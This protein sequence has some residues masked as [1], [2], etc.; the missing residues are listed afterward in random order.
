M[1]DCTRAQRAALLVG[2]QERDEP[3]VVERVASVPEF[4]GRTRQR[5]HDAARIRVDRR[6]RRVD[7]RE[8]VRL[9]PR[10]RRE[11]RPV[12]AL[13]D[14]DPQ[15]EVAW[16]EREAL[17]QRQDVAAYV[18]DGVRGTFLLVEDEQVVLAEHALRQVPEQHTRLGAGDPAP[19]R[20]N[21]APRHSFT[22]T[23]GERFEQPTHRPD[24]GRDPGGAVDDLRP[25]RT[26][27]TKPGVVG[28]ELLGDGGDR[29]E[30]GAQRLREVGGRQRIPPRHAA[31]DPLGE[32][33]VEG[34]EGRRRGIVGTQLRLERH[35]CFC[36]R[37]FGRSTFT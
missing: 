20:R 34:V 28:D 7:Q 32:P 3:A 5:L 31:G 10:H 27:C 2:C 21:R 13:V 35:D 6:Q 24:V 1:S 14:G 17:L 4:F 26:G 25:R 19:D 36:P 16:P 18:V 12:R 33:P 15:P 37:H 22:D 8:V 23:S 11:L 29:G 30:V 9:H